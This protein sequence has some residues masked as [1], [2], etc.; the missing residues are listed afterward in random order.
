M[1][2]IP[3][4][5]QHQPHRLRRLESVWSSRGRPL[6]FVTFCTAER[7]RWLDHPE[8]H[9]AFQDFCVRSPERAAVWIGKYVLMQDHIHMFVSAEGSQRLSSWVGSL[10]RNLAAARRRGCNPGL[11]G[12][13]GSDVGRHCT[14]DVKY[15][16][17]CNPGL[18]GR[19]A[20]RGFNPG[21]Q[22]RATCGIGAAERAWQDG[23][24][25]HVLRDC[26]SYGEKWEYMRMNPVRAGLVVRPEDWPYV[27]EIETLRW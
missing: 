12:G 4:D 15:A 22:D 14:G 2:N 19:T 17:D 23:F 8:I 16:R 9:L 11:Q 25:D 24:F 20:R 6:F 26:E 13:M 7:Q 5:E 27:G 1:A 10:K 3:K 21:L 18:Q